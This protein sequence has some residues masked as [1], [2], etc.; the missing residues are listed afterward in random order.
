MKKSST[1]RKSKF[2]CTPFGVKER[3]Q[4]HDEVTIA[5]SNPV[6]GAR[7]GKTEKMS[8]ALCFQNATR[9]YRVPMTLPSMNDVSACGKNSSS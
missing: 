7:P 9:I 6:L 4:K 5:I 3:K 1:R 2:N 8:A